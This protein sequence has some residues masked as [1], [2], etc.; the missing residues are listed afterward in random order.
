MIPDGF[1]PHRRSS[2]VTAPWEPIYARITPTAY[3]LGLIIGEPHTNSRGL[4]HGGVIAA[5]A[6]NAM[7]L[8]CALGYP[9]PR[10]LV[11]INLNVDYLG[12]AK[13]GQWLEVT[14]GFVQP[15]GTLAFASC[16]VTADGKPCAKAS[17]TFR[18]LPA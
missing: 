4:L 17:A 16:L 2:P 18:V 5:L 6:D 10:P 12:L 3:I 8:S 11:T 1:A 15:G 7:G 13:L 9:E 14:T